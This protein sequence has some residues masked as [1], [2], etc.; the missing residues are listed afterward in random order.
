MSETNKRK[1]ETETAA[2]APN[3]KLK[4]VNRPLEE[5]NENSSIDSLV[6]LVDSNGNLA[7]AAC[8]IFKKK[9]SDVFVTIPN[10][11]GPDAENKASSESLL[12]HFGHLITKLEIIC[13]SQIRPLNKS[14]QDLILEKCRASLLEIKICNA[15]R[16]V[17]GTLK[18]PLENVRAVYFVG[19]SLCG[20]VE[21][22]DR[23][24]PNAHTMELME[25]K[26][27]SKDKKPFLKHYP[28]LEHFA[29]THNCQG[30]GVSL[31]DIKQFITLN[32]Q[33]KSLRIENDEI[34]RYRD[35]YRMQKNGMQCFDANDDMG[36]DDDFVH[37]LPNLENLHLQLNHY[38]GDQ[39]WY[40]EV[41]VPF[42]QLKTLTI[43]FECCVILYGL[44]ISTE[45]LDVLNILGDP[46]GGDSD[47]CAEIVSQNKN[48]KA[49]N[50]TGSLYPS[51]CKRL[52]ALLPTLS[53]LQQLQLPYRKDVQPKEVFALLSSCKVLNKLTILIDQQ[54]YKKLQ[55]LFAVEIEKTG[56]T[57]KSTIEVEGSTC[58]IIME[59]IP[60]NV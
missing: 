1:Q 35:E 34:K 15:N 55:A 25:L 10:E 8:D 50:I 52:F 7:T 46:R 19:K 23:F 28:K 24:F 31:D 51:E 21:N 53:K 3:K 6:N 20:L 42:K 12:K 45:E 14:F 17:F 29:I 2:N 11:I 38:S 44:N 37:L 41:E 26:F 58:R 43:E 57:W 30:R 60:S 36:I 47:H 9:F 59:K 32:E 18:V 27:K 39:R 4:T 49:I 48:A 22:F 5:L 40:E 54:V 33:L 16:K 13:N 56:S